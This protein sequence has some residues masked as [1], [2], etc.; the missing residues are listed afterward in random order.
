MKFFVTG[1]SGFI[2]RALCRALVDRGDEVVVLS[3]KPELDIPGVEVFL[4]DIL[5][6]GDEL[7]SQFENIDVIVN[8]MGEVRTEKNMY[9]LHVNGTRRLI[10]SFLQNSR[11]NGKSTRFIQLSSVGAYGM[12][13][14]SNGREIEVNENFTP[15]PVGQ[16]EVSKTVADEL[17]ISYCAADPAMTFTILRPTNVVG[18]GMTNQSFYQLGNMVRKGAFFYIGS[19]L[20]VANYIHVEDVVRALVLCATDERAKNKIYIVSNDCSLR[21]VVCSMATL[22]KVRFPRLVFSEWLARLSIAL[23]AP[24]PKFPLTKGRVDALVS[25]VTY[26]GEFIKTELGFAPIFDIPSSVPSILAYQQ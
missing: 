15:F 21:E 1:G 22:Y 10:N 5:D 20:S 26:S 2:G 6:W 12:A 3:R 11:K 23:F 7:P 4:G 24:I 14:K 16:Y 19:S 17:V 18:Q 13:S 8:C 25:K 9:E